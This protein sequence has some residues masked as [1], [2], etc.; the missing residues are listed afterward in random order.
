MVLLMIFNDIGN[1]TWVVVEVAVKIEVGWPLRFVTGESR[2]VRTLYHLVSVKCE[3][4]LRIRK[5]HVRML[6]NR[7]GRSELSEVLILFR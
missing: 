1:N 4:C 5:E 6:I 7:E 3:V 2:A